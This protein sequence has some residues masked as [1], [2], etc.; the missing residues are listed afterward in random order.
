LASNKGDDPT[1]WTVR[2][3]RE[4]RKELTCTSS[5]QRNWDESG[6]SACTGPPTAP[7][8]QPGI[9][10]LTFD[11]QEFGAVGGRLRL[12]SPQAGSADGRY[13]IEIPG[14][15]AHVQVTTE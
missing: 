4:N 5:G 2:A 13:Q 15:A 10:D 1:R 3:G 14:N 6:S 7:T 9:T 8:H 11:N 12:E